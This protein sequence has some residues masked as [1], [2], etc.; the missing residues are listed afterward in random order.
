MTDRER[1]DA[2]PDSPR[3]TQLRKNLE[4]LHDKFDLQMYC[5]HVTEV[6]ETLANEFGSAL[7]EAEELGVE[8]FVHYSY[9]HNNYKNGLYLLREGEKLFLEIANAPV[10]NHAAEKP[11]ETR[12]RDMIYALANIGIPRDSRGFAALAAV[13]STK[14]L[15]ERIRTY[16]ARMRDSLNDEEIIGEFDRRTFEADIEEARRRGV[17]PDEDYS[18]L[19]FDV[20][21]RDT[22]WKRIYECEEDACHRKRTTR[23]TIA[24]RFFAW[25][26][27]LEE[28]RQVG[29]DISM[30]LESFE[31]ELRRAEE[32]DPG[33]ER[34]MSERRLV[35]EAIARNRAEDATK[36]GD[37]R[38]G[39]AERNSSGESSAL[40]TP[41]RSAP[42]VSR[43]AATLDKPRR[44]RASVVG[45]IASPVDGF[46][47]NCHSLVGKHARLVLT[48]L[49]LSGPG[50]A[51]AYTLF[52]GVLKSIRSNLGDLEG[53]GTEICRRMHYA[54]VLDRVPSDKSRLIAMRDIL[55][56]ITPA[57]T[58]LTSKRWQVRIEK[59]RNPSKSFIAELEAANRRLEM[60]AG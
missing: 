49:P 9:S 43:I 18:T 31:R 58:R 7:A 37:E 35:R 34:E 59:L 33:L 22:C 11:T 23:I 27:R 4:R 42:S 8:F 19:I 3:A 14:N 60:N 25:E 45:P 5:R 36:N 57:V 52:L 32:E 56:G 12:V 38:R 15:L 2:G 55:R 20:R 6:D 39:D 30:R 53:T 29:M 44:H 17:P 51:T 41:P 21:V 13:A 54:G 48:A 40:A 24:E 26:D 47:A 10:G 46:L 50:S 28:A 1:N 16:A